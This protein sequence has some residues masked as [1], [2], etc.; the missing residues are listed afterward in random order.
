MHYGDP[1]NHIFNKCHPFLNIS[2][3]YVS[4]FQENWFYIHFTSF[5]YFFP[6]IVTMFCRQGVTFRTSPRKWR[7]DVKPWR[8]IWHTSLELCP[9]GILVLSLFIYSLS[10]IK[11]NAFDCP[12]T[13]SSTETCTLLTEWLLVLKCVA[14]GLSL[15]SLMFRRCSSI[16]SFSCLPVSPTYTTLS[17]SVHVSPYITSLSVHIDVTPVCVLQVFQSV[18]QA[19]LGRGMSLFS[20][21]WTIIS[22]R[23]RSLL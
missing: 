16:L 15:L 12:C 10:W 20:L 17:H 22:A 23:L 14:T 18:S 8:Y 6:P 9:E 5:F 2:A 3:L 19:C 7:H 11:H 21:P 4:L 1:Y 13:L